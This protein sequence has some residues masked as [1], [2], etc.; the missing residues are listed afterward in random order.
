ML[1]RTLEALLG[2]GQLHLGA[3]AGGDV[4]GHDER[5]RAAVELQRGAGGLDVDHSAVEP[6]QLLLD[7]LQRRAVRGRERIR[8]APGSR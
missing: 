6:D 4:A 5:R 8:R 7:V 1:E 3:L 2:G